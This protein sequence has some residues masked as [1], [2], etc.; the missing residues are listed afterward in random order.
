MTGVTVAYFDGLGKAEV[1]RVLLTYLNVEFK[2]VRFEEIPDEIRAKCSF[3]QVPYYED[4]EVGSLVE[5]NAIVR[6]IAAKYNIAGKDLVEKAKIDS[7]YESTD[8]VH[9]LHYQANKKGDEAEKERVRTVAIP[10][11]FAAWEKLLSQSSTKFFFGDSITLAD[12]AVFRV[13]GHVALFGYKV[14][15]TPYPKLDALVNHIGSLPQ[16]AKYI[17]ARKAS[18][19]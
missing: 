15:T 2:D 7:I 14:S 18:T 10:K 8:D 6:Y 3:G 16:I 19:F 12:I 13:I 1:I 11:F 5:T 17:S 9:V 4:S